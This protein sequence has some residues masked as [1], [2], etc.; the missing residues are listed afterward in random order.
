[1]HVVTGLGLAWDQDPTPIHFRRARD[2]PPGVWRGLVCREEMFIGGLRALP[3]P[4]E[5]QK[6]PLPFK[7]I[8]PANAEFLYMFSHPSSGQTQLQC[9]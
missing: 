1:L 3:S 4:H 7:E 5:S 8:C 6:Y 9:F 2:L